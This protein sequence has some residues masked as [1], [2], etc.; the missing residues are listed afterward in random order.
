LNF[1]KTELHVARS[2][3]MVFELVTVQ[4]LFLVLHT[5]KKVQLRKVYDS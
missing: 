1:S 2:I 5:E 3:L 4:L